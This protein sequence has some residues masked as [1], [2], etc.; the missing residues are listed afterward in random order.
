MPGSSGAGPS[1]STEALNAASLIVAAA[2]QMA[3]Q[4]LASVLQAAQQA[5]QSIQN[6][7]QIAAQ[8]QFLGY[9]PPAVEQQFL[10]G[11][12][13]TS[14]QQEPGPS[15]Y[16]AT[17]HPP[18]LLPNAPVTSVH[19]PAGAGPPST[20]NPFVNDITSILD[21]LTSYLESNRAAE[22]SSSAA[23]PSNGQM[24][25][26]HDTTTTTGPAQSLLQQLLASVPSQQAASS[27]KRK[28]KGG[29][30]DDDEPTMHPCEYGDCKKSF[31]RKSDLL[32]HN[33]IH[34]GE[35]PF[36]CMICGK[37]FIQVKPSF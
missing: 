23:G 14:L 36:S 17:P 37:T 9:G 32:R 20:P 16:P 6:A 24:G 25:Q 15:P 18:Q 8:R 2:S 12:A 29:G 22:G 11:Y 3:P 10:H 26:S 33:R 13:P 5:A 4:S 19:P 7:N 31:S 28:R 34:T 35:R 30:S 27:L 1:S 21:H